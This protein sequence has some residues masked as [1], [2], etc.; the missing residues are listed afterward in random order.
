M[1]ATAAGASEEHPTAS[2]KAT[3]VPTGRTL[4]EV[5]DPRKVSAGQ[6]KVL[7]G[8]RQERT[9][10]KVDVVRVNSGTLV[11]KDLASIALSSTTP[12]VRLKS[13]SVQ[14]QSP[15]NFT[16]LGGIAGT[17]YEARLSVDDGSVAGTIQQES[18]VY[19]LRPLGDGL[20][21][22]IERDTFR[23]IDH[24]PSSKKA[25]EK[26]HGVAAPDRR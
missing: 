26:V 12:G 17:P 7:E 15:A 8:L 9:A 25:N 14:M 1:A 16:W 18:C 22:M 2:A 5:V 23:V 20:S 10:A 24:P 19:E 4:L 21:A 6:A 11:E 3:T 13:H